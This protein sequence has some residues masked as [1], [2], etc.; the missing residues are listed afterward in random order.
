[1]DISLERAREILDGAAGRRVAVVGDVMLDRYIWGAASRISQEAPV[2]I[3]RALRT[4]SAPGGAANVA[5][6]VHALGARPVPFGVIGQDPAGDE[7][8]ALLE[9]MTDAPAGIVRDP[10]RR[11][12]EKTRVIAGSQ[13]VVRV[14]SEDDGP[15]AEAVADELLARLRAAASRVDAIVVEDYAKGVVGEALLREV[16]AI[17]RARGVPVTLDPH[18]S[19]PYN[20]PGL[21]AMSPNRA[22]AFALAGLYPAKTVL[23]LIDD[24]PLRETA[25]RLAA[26]WAPEYLLVTLGA[27]GIALFRRDSMPLHFPTRARE[28][29]DVSGAGDT[30]IAAFTLALIA[31]A[32]PEEACILGNHA[33]G[34]VVAK[35]GT[36]PVHA[37][38]LLKKWGR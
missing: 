20:V 4:T 11:T 17:G 1:M 3:V 22:E 10:S 6:N 31:G 14:D 36:A 15:L 8:A 24:A 5:R 37:E 34:V 32:A 13:Q 30:V 27:D 18:S 12:T 23:P 33:A 9:A 26:L 35:I 2:P 7:L 28:V 25:V 16:V 19:H 38:E 29:Y 21:T